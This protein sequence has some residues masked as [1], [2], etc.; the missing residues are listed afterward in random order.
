L[1]SLGLW[2]FARGVYSYL[3]ETAPTRHGLLVVEG[4][5]PEEAFGGA[6][7]AFRRGSYQR[8]VVTGGPIEDNACAGG[9]ATYA[10]LAAM[11]VRSLGIREAV[12]AIVPAPASAQE[13]TF[14]SAVSVRQWVEATGEP[15]VAL[16]VY[17]YGA[18]ARRSRWLFQLAFGQ[19]VSVGVLAGRPTT[20][21]PNRWWRSSEGTRAV[22]SELIT[23][24]WVR[25][26]FQPG[27]RGSWEEQ[28][29]PPS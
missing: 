17:S 2:G 7:E 15:I 10:D 23:W 8:F 1:G 21:A 5:M 18:H 29:G 19:K 12:L 26:F 14:R 9:F 25:L 27:A 6:I 3:A 28:W 24:T 13:R 16:D 11:R 22:L 20:F 4:W